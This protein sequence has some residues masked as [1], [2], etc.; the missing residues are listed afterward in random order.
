MGSYDFIDSD[1][2]DIS[3]EESKKNLEELYRRVG[4]NKD[5]KNSSA[6]DI[7]DQSYHATYAHPTLNSNTNPSQSLR[8]DS[9]LKFRNPNLLQSIGTKVKSIKRRGPAPGASY[10]PRIIKKFK[11]GAD[12]RPTGITPS[13]SKYLKDKGYDLSNMSKSEKR[14]L[15]ASYD[16]AYDTST[17][18]W[19][20]RVKKTSPRIK[21]IFAK[22][23][24]KLTNPKSQT[25][26]EAQRQRFYDSQLQQSYLEGNQTPLNPAYSASLDTNRNLSRYNQQLNLSYFQ[27]IQN[28][29]EHRKKVTLIDQQRR[30]VLLSQQ[31]AN[32]LRS[33]NMFSRDNPFMQN[34]KID[35]LQNTFALNDENN[36]MK[37]KS[38]SLNLLST[39]R[40]T[41]LQN[42]DN[43]LNCPNIFGPRIY[44]INTG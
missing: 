10:K 22:A 27:Y 34:C 16:F 44:P 12:G 40:P 33:E 9:K 13:F 24:S 25:T 32:Q 41:I 29:E 30:Q 42:S 21:A 15:F 35:V 8:W 14:K 17:G 39:G 18:H 37:S 19:K 3:S 26:W 2:S 36:I 6:Q 4:L 5:N 11:Y 1:D 20:Y 28:L 38:Y 7:I 43:I 23:Y 31:T